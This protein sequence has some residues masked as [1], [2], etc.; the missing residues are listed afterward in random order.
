MSFRTLA[1][2]PHEGAAY[3]KGDWTF[4]GLGGREGP[5]AA[6]DERV[7]FDGS[8]RAW[9]KQGIQ[10]WPSPEVMTN[11]GAKGAL[12]EIADLAIG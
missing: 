2:G 11:M 9:Q 6:G 3:E 12:C 10:V 5:N 1:P 4:C 8:M 7:K